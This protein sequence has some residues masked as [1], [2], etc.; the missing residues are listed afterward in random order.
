M[1]KEQKNLTITTQSKV[2]DQKNFTEHYKQNEMYDACKMSSDR[3]RTQKK[4][5]NINPEE[6][7]IQQAL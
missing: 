4:S 6:K 5:F 3:I 1:C 2:Y 7:D